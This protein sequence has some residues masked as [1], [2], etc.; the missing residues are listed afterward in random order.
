MRI[1]II[2]SHK[3]WTPQTEYDAKYVIRE[4]LYSCFEDSDM[5]PVHH[6]F[7][8]GGAKG[9]DTFGEQIAVGELGMKPDIYLPDFKRYGI[10]AAYFVRNKLIAENSGFLLALFADE[11]V[12]NGTAD[13]IKHALKLKKYVH[14]WHPS[15]GLDKDEI[16]LWNHCHP[17]YNGYHANPHKECTLR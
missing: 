3:D 12:T 13:T 8:S 16:V 7:V 2:G 14:V 4:F 15:F 11:R 9:A 17:E 1:G 6:T 10:P 5:L